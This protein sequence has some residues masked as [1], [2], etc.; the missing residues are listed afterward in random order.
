M[1]FYLRIGFPWD[2]Q[3]TN[4]FEIDYIKN[5]G[6]YSIPEMHLRVAYMK[7]KPKKEKIIKKPKMPEYKIPNLR[8]VIIII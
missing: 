8:Y 5:A 6:Q 1:W 3:F 2:D 7:P 4:P